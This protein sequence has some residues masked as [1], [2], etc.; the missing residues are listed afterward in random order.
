M[1]IGTAAPA[2]E[3]RV[4][5]EEFRRLTSGSG[6]WER[7]TLAIEHVLG[8]EVAQAV[9]RALRDRRPVTLHPTNAEITKRIV[10]VG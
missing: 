7:G 6:Q 4:S 9:D 3:I 1:K 2:L 10:D 8:L 5:W